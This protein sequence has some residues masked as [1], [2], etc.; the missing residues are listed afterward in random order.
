MIEVTPSQLR[1]AVDKKW[2]TFSGT[3][4][5]FYNEFIKELFGDKDE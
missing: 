3:K 1:K 2:T 5:E 4:G